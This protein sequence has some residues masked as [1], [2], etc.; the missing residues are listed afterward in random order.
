MAEEC[1]AQVLNRLVG[2]DRKEGQKWQSAVCGARW[3]GASQRRPQTG[4]LEAGEGLSDATQEA[5]CRSGR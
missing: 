5:A 3:V 4:K 2:K 1:S